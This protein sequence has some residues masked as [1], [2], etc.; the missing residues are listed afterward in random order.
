M[1]I[2]SLHHPQ[3]PSPSLR[4]LIDEYGAE[5]P[6]RIPGSG[7]A[8]SFLGRLLVQLYPGWVPADL[9][10]GDAQQK[11]LPINL[12]E[13]GRK[14]EAAL[15]NTAQLQ[16]AFAF[17]GATI[18]QYRSIIRRFLVWYEATYRPPS[19]LTVEVTAEWQAL[20]ALIRAHTGPGKLLGSRGRMG[21][22]ATFAT[23]HDLGVQTLTTADTEALWHW[24]HNEGGVSNPRMYYSHIR[25]AWEKLADHQLV[26]AVSFFVP[27]RRWTRYG[28]AKEEE[29]PPRLKAAIEDFARRASPGAGGDPAL[30]LAPSTLEARLGLLRRLL[31]FV[32][33]EMRVD[34]QTLTLHDLFA[35]SQ[36][37]I[38]FHYA[39]CQRKGGGVVMKAHLHELGDLIWIGERYI[40]PYQGPVDMAWLRVYTTRAG[41]IAQR[42]PDPLGA[43]SRA[44]VEQVLAAM[45]QELEL[46][47]AQ[48]WSPG[49]LLPVLRDRFAMQFHL[50][51]GNRA[52]DLIDADLGKEVRADGEG[53]LCRF[54]T[55][56]QP[57]DEFHLS[58]AASRAFHRYWAHRE[59]MGLTQP[60]MLITRTGQRLTRQ[61]LYEQVV[62]WFMRVLGKPYSVHAFRYTFL[63]EELL[64]HGDSGL[65]TSRLGNSS[66]QTTNAFYNRLLPAMAAVQW[67]ALLAR[68]LAGEALVPL[69]W[70]QQLLD[71]VATDPVLYRQVAQTLRQRLG[72]PA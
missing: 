1:Y 44:E 70:A 23:L 40:T 7:P 30:Q 41:P 29:L 35:D 11:A 8:F 17:S 16:L 71:R 33:K 43:C 53:F 12:L 52:S 63:M 13:D 48:G 46:G 47:Q 66:V 55:K 31:G 32:R 24:L 45:D 59:Q 69:V 56:N 25:K 6:D 42:R 9:E 15:K 61:Q 38:A 10:P 3:A 51:H 14:I 27:S 28:I 36:Y 20:L 58:A 26:P 2:P 54:E 4:Q 62:R 22:L 37:L 49:A 5:Y 21:K 68:E 34:L 50:D 57:E 19:T 65:A 18:R 72:G 67:H 64:R 39:Q 60:A